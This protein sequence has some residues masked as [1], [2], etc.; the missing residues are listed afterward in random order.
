MPNKKLINSKMEDWDISYDEL[1]IYR[2]WC[3]FLL[4]NKNLNEGEF[5]ISPQFLTRTSNKRKVEV[6]FIILDL[7]FANKNK[8]R[9]LESSYYRVIYN[10]EIE[11]E[12]QTIGEQKKSKEEMTDIV[13]KICN[14][15]NFYNGYLFLKK[16]LEDCKE[17][18]ESV[19]MGIDQK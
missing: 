12:A 13:K 11:E 8:D 7:S 19:L 5:I 6:R 18:L 9:F 3:L 17:R 1:I 10:A 15:A 2:D 14:K 16:D 4:E